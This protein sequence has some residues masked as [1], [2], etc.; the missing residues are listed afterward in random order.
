MDQLVMK[1]KNLVL[2]N[3]PIERELNMWKSILENMIK[4]GEKS[5]VRKSKVDGTN[6]F[7]SITEIKNK[8]KN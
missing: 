1:C 5:F 4:K 7:Y 8:I 3:L 2:E 6:L